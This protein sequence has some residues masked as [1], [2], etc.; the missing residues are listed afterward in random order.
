MS[1]TTRSSEGL[2]ERRRR[3]LFRAWH[4]G[5]REIDL[6]IGR[7]A[8][9]HIGTLSDAELDEFEQLIEVPGAAISTP[10]SPAS[11]DAAGR[12][13]TAAVPPDCATSSAGPPDA[14][15]CRP[16]SPPPN[17]SPPAAR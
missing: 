13:D 4:R 11:A 12:H 10:G 7:F 5:M 15:R 17:C 9:A 16:Q 1:G 6:I 8:D 2:D 3:L 14:W